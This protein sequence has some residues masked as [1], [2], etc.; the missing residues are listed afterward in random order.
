MEGIDEKAIRRFVSEHL[1]QCD[2]P[3]P[4]QRSRHMIRA[5][6]SHLIDLLRARGAVL[7]PAGLSEHMTSEISG[8]DHYM[9]ATCGLAA[10]TRRQRV[11]MLTQFL[12]ARFGNGP[13]KATAIS[14]T[15][16]R[17]F[18]VGSQVPR[19][20]GLAREKAHALRCYLQYRALSGDPVD[21]LI[22]TIPR[23]PCWQ[24]ATLPVTLSKAEVQQL[25]GSFDGSLPSARRAY[26]I[27][28]C[29]ADLGLRVSEVA[30]LQ[31]DDID[32]QAGT[33]R[34]RKGKS[35]RTDILPLPME[36][37]QA[38]AEYLRG[39]RPPTA[40]R[41]VF[42]RHV[43][44]YDKPIGTGAVQKV[45]EAA[46]RRCGWRHTRTHL[47]R[48]S[49]ATQLLKEGTPLK[50]IA[51]LLRHRSLDTSKIYAKVDTSRLSAVALPWPGRAP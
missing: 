6:L 47:L 21:L 37:G 44:P 27:V 12:T 17:H 39:E 4:V 35:R 13:I 48:H 2:C 42:V 32:W 31:L 33:L 5:A 14:A 20:P 19:G 41:A 50:E 43:A 49:V 45:V 11:R 51:D 9:E 46:Y 30:H 8:F 34:I 24:Q 29:F 26:A 7:A 40:N 23:P 3:Y 22:G 15:E 38:I 1:P 36:T 10:S 25:L 16:L 28:R 18:V